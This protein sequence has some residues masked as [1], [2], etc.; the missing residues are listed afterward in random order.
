MVIG[1]DYFSGKNQC[2]GSSGGGD[3]NLF[4]SFRT[5]SYHIIPI[6]SANTLIMTF[7]MNRKS[8]ACALLL[9]FLILPLM[10]YRSLA[11]GTET[12][13][14]VKKAD[15][16]LAIKEYAQALSLYLELDKSAPKDPQTNYA[17]GFCYANLPGELVKAI[18]YFEFATKSKGAEVPPRAYYY[19]GKAYHLEGKFDE[20]INQ[21]NLYKTL[22]RDAAKLADATRQVQVCVNAKTLMKAPV[23]VYVQNI[24]APINTKDTEYGVVISADEQILIYTSLKPLPADKNNPTAKPLEYEDILISRKTGSGW[25]SPQSIG[26]VPPTVNNIRSNIGSVGLTP[27]GQKLLLYMGTTTN[28][29]DIFYSQLQGDKWGA[30]VRMGKEVNSNAQESSASITPDEKVM[31]F[32]SNRPG[33]YGGMDI[34]KV[35]K[36][37]SGDWGAPV[38]LGATVNTPYDEE[39]PFIHPDK[40]TLY[41]TS[42]G[43]NSMGGDDI[44]KAVLDNGTGKW[45]TPVNM[46]YP[47]NTVHNDSYFA[48]SA[49]GKK[50]YFSSDRPGGSGGQDIYFLGIPEEQGVVPL[51]MMKGRILAGDPPKPIPT[52]IK[53][54]NNE[55]KEVIKDVYNPNQKTGDYLVI[56]PPNKSYDM[57]I[58]AEGYKPY[59]VNIHVPNQ[60]YFYELYQEILLNPVTKDGK[61][62]GQEISVKNAFYDVEKDAEPGTVKSNNSDIF[63]LMGNIMSASDSAALKALLE[64]AYSDPVDV[65]TIAKN[66]VAVGNTYMYADASGKLQPLVVGSDTLYTMAALNT[67]DLYK[68]NNKPKETITKETV[69]KPNQIYIVYFDTDK[70]NLKADATPE[71]EK[72]YDFLKRNPKFGVKISGYTDSD[73][74]KERNQ[75]IS[76]NRAKEVAKYLANKGIIMERTLARGYGSADPLNGNANDQEKKLNRRVEIM[77]VELRKVN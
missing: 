73:G 74:T 13:K 26:L 9:F 49:D 61:V 28:T 31:Y 18:P 45:S 2:P 19:L 39:A 65:S 62:V 58:E 56:F 33:G 8:Y 3:R 66:E 48:L 17:I 71:L 75:V 30:P 5:A 40:K 25:S 69:I 60:T 53:V 20:A 77:L 67:A 38:N 1:T 36:L 24:G 64:V 37:A 68:T 46:G 22:E 11:Q 7:S 6:C 51:T 29:G 76:D 54:I 16:F 35:E 32:A 12:E 59:L 43:H 21:F 23:D 4:F 15:S 34:Y 10:S 50:G 44:F 27:N 70:T 47:V 63:A 42:D 57:V 14:K 55:T 52:K 41:F 72:V